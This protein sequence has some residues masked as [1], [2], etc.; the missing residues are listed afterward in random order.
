MSAPDHF[1]EALDK[2]TGHSIWRIERDGYAPQRFD[3][4]SL[5]E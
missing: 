1:V 5:G 4:V 3:P 2:K